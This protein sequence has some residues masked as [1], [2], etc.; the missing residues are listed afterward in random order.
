MSWTSMRLGVC[1]SHPPHAST[2]VFCAARMSG[3]PEAGK[4]IDSSSW[5]AHGCAVSSSRLL[6]EAAAAWRAS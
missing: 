2:S 5:A 1:A 3:R 4:A 6:S